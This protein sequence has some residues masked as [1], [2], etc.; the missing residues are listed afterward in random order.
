[1]S[2]LYIFIN[3][4]ILKYINIHNKLRGSSDFYVFFIYFRILAL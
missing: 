1:M 4:V 2:C 3:F